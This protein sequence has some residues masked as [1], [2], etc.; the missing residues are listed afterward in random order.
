MGQSSP[1]AAARGQE[2]STPGGQRD[3]LLSYFIYLSWLTIKKNKKMKSMRD[4]EFSVKEMTKKTCKFFYTWEQTLLFL[5]FFYPG[6]V[7]IWVSKQLSQLPSTSRHD[8]PGFF[9]FCATDS[10]AA[11]EDEAFWLSFGI[12]AKCQQ[13]S[14][15]SRRAE[16]TG[17]VKTTLRPTAG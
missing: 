9:S 5:L 11:G 17:C 2:V 13:L 3:V 8:R 1:A 15:F 16:G 4:N 7:V 10:V 12:R 14:A 6:Y